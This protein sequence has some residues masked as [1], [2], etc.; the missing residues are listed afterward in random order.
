MPPGTSNAKMAPSPHPCSI[1]GTGGEE[2]EAKEKD[3]S[4]PECGHPPKALDLRTRERKLPLT[5]VIGRRRG[6]MLDFHRVRNLEAVKH[7]D[8]DDLPAA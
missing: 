4:P 8:R 1:G 7:I 6:N 3:V 2:E 5:L